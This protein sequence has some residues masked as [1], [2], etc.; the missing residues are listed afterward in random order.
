MMAATARRSQGSR[1]PPSNAA[2]LAEVHSAKDQDDADDRDED[3][4]AAAGQTRR[5]APHP[6]VGFR[7][8]SLGDRRSLSRWRRYRSTTFR[9]ESPYTTLRR[10]LTELASS[11]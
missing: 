3:A 10:K 8:A 6:T 4:D 5:Q 1:A 11:K 9:V 2:G 7:L